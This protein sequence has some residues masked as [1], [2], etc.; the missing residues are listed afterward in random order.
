MR[1]ANVGLVFHSHAK[2]VVSLFL[3]AHDLPIARNKYSSYVE[4]H[5]DL[6]C[7][8]G[9]LIS[10]ALGTHQRILK[11]NLGCALVTPLRTEHMTQKRASTH[12]SNRGF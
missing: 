7:N 12:D 4:Y 10:P 8:G 9:P 3:I 1:E 11:Q 2:A 6:L 5:D